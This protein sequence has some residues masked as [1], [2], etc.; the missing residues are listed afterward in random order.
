[1]KKIGEYKKLVVDNR[2][3]TL[4]SSK[5]RYSAIEEIL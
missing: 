1:M 3:L 2:R 4:P 5:M